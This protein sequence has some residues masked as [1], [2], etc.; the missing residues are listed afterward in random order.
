MLVATIMEENGD[1]HTP[2]ELHRCDECGKDL[3]YCAPREEQDDK[4]YCGDCAFIKGLINEEQ[5]KE[6]HLF[7]LNIPDLRA[8][9]HDGKIYVD[10]GKFPWERESRDRN[11][12]DYFIWRTKVFERDDYTCQVC[13]QRG[14]ELNAHHKKPY[15]KYPELRTELDNGITLCVKCHKAAHKSRKA[16]CK[17]E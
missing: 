7:W 8:V 3:P 15:S 5:Y 17:N 11:Y 10:Q 13:G 12:Q 6:R 1:T 4:D 9:V 2:I 16:V 14:G